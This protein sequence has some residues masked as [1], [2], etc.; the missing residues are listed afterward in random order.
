MCPLAIMVR[1][2]F[3][4]IEL[5]FVEGEV[6]LA[7]RRLGRIPAESSFGSVRKCHWFTGGEPWLWVVEYQL[8]SLIMRFCFVTVPGSPVS[9]HTPN[10]HAVFGRERPLC[11]VPSYEQSAHGDAGDGPA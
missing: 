10:A 1:Q 3:I 2:P 6:Q 9:Q 11:A 8:Q 4:Q 7:A 5:Q